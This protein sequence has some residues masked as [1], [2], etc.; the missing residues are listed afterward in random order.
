MPNDFRSISF[1]GEQESGKGRGHSSSYFCY[2]LIA[3]HTRSAGHVAYQAQ[4]I[5][6]GCY[7]QGRFCLAA[8]AAYF[9]SGLHFLTK[10]ISDSSFLDEVNLR[11]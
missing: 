4:G 9:D 6:T 2:F 10:L 11:T 5:R 8:D 7:G 3:D 1:A